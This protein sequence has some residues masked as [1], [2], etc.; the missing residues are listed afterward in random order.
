MLDKYPQT[1][2]IAFKNLPLTSIHKM[3]MPAALAALAANN[4]GKFWEMHD[5]I[6]AMKAKITADKL[7]E[8]AR[9]IGLDLEKFNADR[10]S[11]E[12]RKKLAKDME[13][14]KAVQVSGTPTLFLNGRR[15]QDRSLNALQRMI[16]EEAAKAK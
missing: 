14:A 12:L 8:A 1:L 10:N 6:F 11:E 13:D 9:E 2:K 5:A 3:A 7:N 4:Q 15:V 16:E